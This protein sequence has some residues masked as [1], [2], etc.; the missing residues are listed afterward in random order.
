MSQVPVA[1]VPPQPS[2]P[3]HAAPEQLGVQPV[4]APPVHAPPLVHFAHT[5]PARPHAFVAVPGRHVE[6]AQQPLHDVGSHAQIPASQ[7]WPVPQLPVEQTPPQPSVAP[8]A[9]PAHDGVQLPVPHWLGPPP[10]QVSAPGHAPQS[11]SAPQRP[12]S[13]PQWPA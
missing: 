7:R 11:R 4:H 1:H 8:H 3:P 5:A 9:L 10:P 13:L 2:L 6:P 12:L